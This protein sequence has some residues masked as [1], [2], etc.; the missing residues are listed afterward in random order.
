LSSEAGRVDE[1]GWWKK[2]GINKKLNFSCPVAG[3]T[4]GARE[5]DELFLSQHKRGG[6]AV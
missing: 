2:R 6:R 4:D 3:A 1:S 5:V